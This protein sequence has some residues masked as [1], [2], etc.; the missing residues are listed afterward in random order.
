M[1]DDYLGQPPRRTP[2]PWPGI[3]F[4]LIV[5]LGV[6]AY[7][8]ARSGAPSAA[9]RA[10]TPRAELTELEQTNVE[11]FETMAPG[12]VHVTSVERQLFNSTVASRGTGTGFVWDTNGHIITNYHVIDGGTG[13]WIRFQG[14]SQKITATLVGA[15][16][17]HDIAVLRINETPPGGLHPI[18][19]GSSHDLKVGQTVLAIGNPFGLDHTLT[20][21]IVSALN[22]QIKAKNGRTI[23]GVI[24][25]DAAINPG[26]SG[27]PLL[28][29]A[30]RVIGVN[31]AI[32][33]DVGQSAGIGFAVPIDLV[34]QVIPDLIA[35]G[36]VRRPR[37]GIGLLDRPE[38]YLGYQPKGIVVRHVEP[39]SPADHAGL[40]KVLVNNRG[41]VRGV[42]VITAINGQ[43]VRNYDELRQIL[44]QY[45][46]GDELTLKVTRRDLGHEVE[47]KLTLS[48][49]R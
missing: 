48:D 29:S 28:D 10:V 14:S 40:R 21:G 1:Q 16:P 44:E 19:L 15:E 42:D 26:N 39:D 11:I 2:S 18:P 37:M 45:N 33:S 25:T 3:A 24:Q 27:G 49:P 43:S 46:G 9:L 12:V 41:T 23:Q 47:I 4:L 22:R 20:L 35:Y 31:T 38:S 30:G 34:N 36:H 17:D 6:T 8:V 7:F 32:L 13:I 5:G